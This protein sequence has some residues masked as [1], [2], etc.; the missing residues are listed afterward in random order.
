MIVTAFVLSLIAC[1]GGD[2]KTEK[3]A[4][5][6]KPVAPAPAPVAAPAPP[7]PAAP[8]PPASGPYTPDD[9]AKAAY[10]KAKAAGADAKPNPKKGD[11]AAIAAGKTTYDTKCASCHGAT[12]AGDGAA[13][14][15]F[16]QKPANFSWKERWDGT[17]VGTKQWVVMNGVQGTGMVALGLTEDQAWEVLAHIESTFAPK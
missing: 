15:A 8:A 9:L 5:P 17:S 1:G 7:P 11:A 6:P 3:K 4:E 13:G 12:G 16:P 10:E 14:A 2:T